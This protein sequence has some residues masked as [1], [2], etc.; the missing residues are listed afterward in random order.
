MLGHAATRCRQLRIVERAV[1]AFP[2]AAL[3]AVWWFLWVPNWRPPLREGE[4]YGID[5]SAHQNHVNWPQVD[6]DGVDFAYIKASE[7]W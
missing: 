3:V 6:G 4:H 7:G 5:V 2:L 1:F